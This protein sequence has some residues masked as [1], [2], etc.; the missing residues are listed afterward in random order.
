MQNIFTGRDE[1]PYH[2]S[3]GGVVINASNQILCHHFPVSERNPDDLYIL[4]RE[5]VE[6][7]ETLEQTVILD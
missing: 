3:V 6:N 4:M 7:E 2:L 5:S 1:S